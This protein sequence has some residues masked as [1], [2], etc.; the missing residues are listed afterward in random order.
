MG[1][2]CAAGDTAANLKTCHLKSHSGR[3]L[4]LEGEAVGKVAD[5]GRFKPPRGYGSG[6]LNKIFDKDDPTPLKRLGDTMSAFLEVIK[7]RIRRIYDSFDHIPD[8]H[9]TLEPT[10]LNTPDPSAAFNAYYRR[11]TVDSLYGATDLDAASDPHQESPLKGLCPTGT[12]PGD[13][14]VLLY[15][16]D[17]PLILREQP[18]DVAGGAS[19]EQNCCL[20]PR[21]LAYSL[22]GE[23]YLAGHMN[24]KAFEA[25]KGTTPEWFTL[26]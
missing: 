17:V 22:V 5:L 1:M 10:K 20:P 3:F 11:R 18:G 26:V 24:G 13:I 8:C 9:F 7:H 6:F 21:Q 12:R 15:G 16:G 14:F 23:C 25:R 2:S 4:V 19:P